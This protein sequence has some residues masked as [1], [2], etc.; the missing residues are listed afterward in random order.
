MNPRSLLTCAV[1]AAINTSASATAGSAETLAPITVSAA[2][3]DSPLAKLANNI[4][5]TNEAEMQQNL[6]VN[7]KDA[8]ENTPG[9]SFDGSGRY[10]L[11]DITIRGISGNR[12]K[13][14][15]NGQE[16]NSQFSFGPFQNAGREYMDLN[17]IKQLEVIKGPVSS[18]HGS[19]AIGGVVSL[20]SKTP[21]DYLHDGARFGGSVFTQ[22]SGRDSG[23]NAGGA[24]AAAPH[25]QWDGLIAYSYNHAEENKNHGGLNVSGA[26]RTV[27]DPQRDNSHSVA[28][29][30][31]YKPNNDHTFSLSAGVYHNKRDTNVQSSLGNNMN[32]YNYTAYRGADSQQRTN[33][34][35]RHN[36]TIR[37]PF[38][39]SGYWHTWWQK[40]DST[41][42]TVMDGT[43]QRAGN[44]ATQRYRK[45]EY[46]MTDSGIEAQFNK[47]IDGRVRQNWVYGLT[48]SH[49]DV[50]MQRHT[51]DS[52]AGRASSSHEKNA[53]DSVIDQFGVFAQNRLSF[54]GSGVSLIP[55][56]R[57]DYYRLNAKP[58]T[59]FWHTVG[60][61]YQVSNYREDHF[62]FR[63]GSLYD[64]SN[65]H[66][67]YAN[68]AEGF[69]APAFNETNLGFE[70]P[71]QGYSYIANPSLKPEKSRGIEIGWRSDNG[72][73]NHDLSAYYT[74][75]Y[76]FIQS[77][78]N[79]GRNSQ[80]GLIAFT[81]VNLPSAEIYGVELAAGVNFSG[82]HPRL[83]GL[84][85]DL[86]LAWTDGKN[87]SDNTPISSIAPFSGHIGVN[88]D[89]DERWGVGTHW[90][91]ATKKA[92]KDVSSTDP[93]NTAKGIGGYGVWDV[94]GYYRPVKGLTARAGVF[95]ILDKKY[96]TWGEAYRLGDEISRTRYSAPGRWFGASLRYDF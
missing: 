92:D 6:N 66:T 15:A 75:Y 87:R 26:A 78:T 71:Q 18:L 14:L 45:S 91:F 53:P 60:S 38:A 50:D 17:N 77:Q 43:L 81:S 70:N 23:I 36:F 90:R 42:E 48:Y 52:V 40:Q 80:N 54:G 94:T 65:N 4:R 64:I 12:V 61:S 63:L 69:R 88:Y 95:N 20:V 34:A 5:V 19:D 59:S 16:I 32:I 55:G 29:Q 13:V 74:R 2:R 89:V 24:I 1:L 96:I 35:L 41:Q 67:L 21:D 8:L 68:Y 9:V 82:I 22:Y 25:E 11:S 57:Y 28:G 39:D 47:T 51:R 56:L 93:R 84:S 3:E 76:N 33:A 85:T 31:R 62:S 58:D 83:Q 7:V 86:G 44:A 10:G 49:K 27:P 46:A 73:L 30:I 37:N 72:I 79:I